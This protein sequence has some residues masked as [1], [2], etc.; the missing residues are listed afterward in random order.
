MRKGVYLS[1]RA[2]V[3]LAFV[4]IAAAATIIALSAVYTQERS[5][6]TTS[7]ST[8]SPPPGH[9]DPWH[10]H[11][12]PTSLLPVFYNLTLWPRLEPR[13]DGL[14]FFTGNSS[15]VFDCVNNTELILLH[16]N[17]LNMTSFGLRGLGGVSAPGLRKT[18]LEERTQYLVVQL[19][20]ELQAGSTYELHTEFAGE[21]ADD[22]RG[23]YRSEYEE[24]GE[25]KVLATSQM[26]PT[27]AR[28]VFPCFDE[29]AMKAVFQITLIHPPET[30]ALSNGMNHEP[31]NV[32]V[33]GQPWVRT[34]F[35]PTEKMS[36]YLLAFVVCQFG[37]EESQQ[38]VDV[39]IRIWARRQA[40]E[41]GKGAYALAK[42]G[43]ILAYFERYYNSRYPLEKSD[44]I[45]LPDLNTA[46]MENWGLITYNENAL[47]YNPRLP[48]NGDREYVATVISHELAHMWFGNLVT[49]RWWNDL[50]LNEGFATYVSYLGVHYAEPT[51]NIKDLI[52]LNEVIGV[53]AEDSMA[54]S[55]PLSLKE[56]D[57]QEPEQI[58]QLFDGITYSKG[59]AVLRMLSEFITEEVFSKGLHTYLEEFKYKNTVNADL[60]KHLQM[61][62]EKAGLT[63]PHSVEAIM[64][65]WILQM[66]FPVV[67]IDTQTGTLFQG[68][69]LLDPDTEVKRPSEFN[70]EWFVPVTWMKNGEVASQY[71]LLNK[72]DTNPA[73]ALGPDEWLLANINMVGF[74]RVNYDAHNWE[75]LLAKLD[76]QHQDIPVINRAQIID[77]AFNLARAKMVDLTLALSTTRFLHREV[78]YMPWQVALK[79][80]QHFHLRLDRTDAFGP[81]QAYM[82]KQVTPLFKYFQELTA[83]WTKTPDKHTDQYNQVNAIS[84]ACSAG[85]QGCRDLVTG[86]FSDWMKNSTKTI[87]P[88]LR[89]VVYCSAIAAGG[90]EEW[91]FAWAKFKNAAI[92]SEAKKLMSALAC[93]KQ[94]QLLNRFLEYSLDTEKIPEQL[95][96]FVITHVAANAIGLPLAWSFVLRNWDHLENESFFSL[97][98]VTR[99]FS[100]EFEYQQLLDFK[101]EN[102]AKWDVTYALE[103]TKSKMKWVAEN[104]EQ[105]RDWFAGETSNSAE[106]HR[107]QH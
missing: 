39:L 14:F 85:V 32:T 98:G 88:D 95:A 75:R 6:T 28:K 66:G 69:F 80:L 1:K 93:T 107:P 45:A 102:G 49:M 84:M 72:S 65:R 51:W 64:N 81:M 3:A 4:G 2:A 104:R 10:D 68:H 71:W 34:G 86:W 26:Q 67:T 97:E 99:R 90:V 47:L 82:K 7:T 52:V 19:S 35:E 58:D 78:E 25:N 22:L 74:Y 13:A 8:S 87:S 77:D 41:A 11:R 15:V 42:T 40:I 33:D 76:S 106:S 30:V 53:M 105:V 79:H 16:S 100:T 20:G 31:V 61:A 12:L 54:S 37:Y 50:W 9:Q 94:P 44:Q 73:M 23:F 17:K 70:Y 18:W 29:P 36:T 91:D 103:R 38:G 27:Y 59:A 48:S 46:G 56:E 60:W 63:L 57:V 43:P 92:A 62:V 5:S 89:A 96:D 101:E 83:N 55:H 21:L 24:G